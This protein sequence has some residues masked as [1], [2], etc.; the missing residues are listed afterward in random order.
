LFADTGSA[1]TAATPPA[2]NYAYEPLNQYFTAAIQDFFEYYRT[3]TFEIDLAGT[4]STKWTG[5][6]VGI[7]VGGTDYTVLQLLGETGQYG[8]TYAGDT[9]NIYQPFF[10]SNVPAGTAGLTPPPPPPSWL[11]D[12]AESPS[13]MVFGAD[14][15]FGIPDNTGVSNPTAPLSTAPPDIVK[16]IMNP[17]NAALNRGLTPRGNTVNVLSPMYWAQAPLFP[18]TAS[19]SQAGG[20]LAQGTYYYA[21][22]GVNVNGDTSNQETIPGN[23]V[24]VPS[25][26]LS[27]GNTNSVTLTIP[28]TG[29]TTFSA[30]NVYRG[31]TPDALLKIGSVTPSTSGTTSFTDDGSGSGTTAPP[32]LMN[33]PGQAVNWYAAYLHQLTVSI[34]GFAYGTP[35]DD[36]GS[37]STNVNLTYTAPTP[38]PPQGLTISLLRWE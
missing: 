24:T 5:N 21:I 1:G 2:N 28:N 7:S 16:D 20:T 36:Q 33:A 19:P 38:Q 26:A 32:F 37:F 27:S 23:I 11:L 8:G 35:Y 29:V 22:T 3:N 34:N 18:L 25:S 15:V 6:T 14:G 30:F 13:S 17:I 9:A 12:P 31:T 4:V 10:S